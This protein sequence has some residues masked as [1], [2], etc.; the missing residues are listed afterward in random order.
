SNGQGA[1]L[2]KDSVTA[3]AEFI[4]KGSS[5]KR[6]FIPP[7]M[8]KHLEAE[9]HILL[10]HDGRLYRYDAGVYV[11]DAEKWV[12]KRMRE[13][14][15]DYYRKNQREEVIGWLTSTLPTIAA[16][17]IDVVNLDNGLLD[18]RHDRLRRHDPEVLST[19]RIPHKW[20]PK[21]KCQK[22]D[23]FLN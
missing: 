8:A 10:G 15:G 17:P 22:V 9:G 19:I 12:A 4:G 20:N 3:K 2:V 14:L 1:D 13:I 6:A 5:G 11:A 16:Q 7:R 21:A 23:A 18:W